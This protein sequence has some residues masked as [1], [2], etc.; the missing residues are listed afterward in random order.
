[1]NHGRYETIP[2]K[3]DGNGGYYADYPIYAKEMIS[4]MLM[5]LKIGNAYVDQACCSVRQYAD[6]ILADPVT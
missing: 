4:Q 3:S 2:L 5:G 6:K 1:Q